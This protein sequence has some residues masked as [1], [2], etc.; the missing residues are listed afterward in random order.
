M[1]SGE[2]AMTNPSDQELIGEL[3]APMRERLEGLGPA[4][5]TAALEQMRRFRDS[6]DNQTR[7][8]MERFQAHVRSRPE[9]P[10]VGDTAPGFE[11]DILGGAGAR[12][13]LADLRGRPVGLIF[14]SYT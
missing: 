8:W 4:E 5:R 10:S 11:L 2:G 9:P 12:V 1:L 7:E 3:P 14:G 6:L 13:R